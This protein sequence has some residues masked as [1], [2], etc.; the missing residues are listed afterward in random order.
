MGAA[1]GA[2]RVVGTVVALEGLVVDVVAARVGWAGEGAEGMAEAV[3]ASKTLRRNLSA[4][5]AAVV[6]RSSG[7]VWLWVWVLVCVL[8]WADV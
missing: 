2:G 6:E 5:P 7:G 1:V 4:P 8:V 3:E